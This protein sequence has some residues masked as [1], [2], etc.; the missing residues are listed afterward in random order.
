MLPDAL[1][2]NVMPG[3]FCSL[4][5][6][7]DHISWNDIELLDMADVA[8]NAG[9]GPDIEVHARVD[10]PGARMYGPTSGSSAGSLTRLPAR[11]F[12]FAHWTRR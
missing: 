11:L 6:F 5:V 9:F 2:T 12:V 4:A 7:G 8:T 3:I 1:P 10:P